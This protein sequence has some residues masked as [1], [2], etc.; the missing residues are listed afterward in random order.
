VLGNVLVCILGECMPVCAGGVLA[1]VCWCVLS[2]M[3]VYAGVLSN[4]GGMLVAITGVC[5][6]VIATGVHAGNILVYV[7]VC[8]CMLVGSS[9]MLEC[10]LVCFRW[11]AGVCWCVLVYAGC[12]C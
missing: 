8:W 3:L 6:C 5:W 4:A 7:S 2:G 10:M 9:G 11:H 12:V 1:S